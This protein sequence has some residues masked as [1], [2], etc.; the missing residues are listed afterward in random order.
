MNGSRPPQRIGRSIAAVVVG[1]VATIAVTIVTDIV[2]HAI[3]L[4]PPLGQRVPDPLLLLAT[5]YRTVY[6]IAGSY[7][8]ARLAPARPVLHAMIGGA[9]GFVVGLAGAIATWNAG[10]AFATHWYPVALIVLALPQ[11][12]FGGWLRERQ[13]LPVGSET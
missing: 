5:A 13:M 8:T 10:P 9:L 2:L 12:W 3:K 1:I 6:G 4:F 11:S 7:L